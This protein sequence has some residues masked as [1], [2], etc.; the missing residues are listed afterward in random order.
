MSLLHRVRALIVLVETL[1]WCFDTM[2]ARNGLFLGSGEGFNRLDRLSQVF[3]WS[4]MWFDDRPGVEL[5][6]LYIHILGNTP[7]GY[8][9]D[10]AQCQSKNSALP[11]SY[12]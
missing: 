7:P 1:D 4:W 8:I 10:A 11:I 2:I 12:Q 3:R 5:E 9:P 6:I